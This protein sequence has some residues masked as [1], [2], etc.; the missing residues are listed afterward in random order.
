LSIEFNF[1][2]YRYSVTLSFLL[3]SNLG[4]LWT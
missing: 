1:G 3:S 4:T 2:S